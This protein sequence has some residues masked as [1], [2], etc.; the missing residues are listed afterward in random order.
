M[1]ETSG[2]QRVSVTGLTPVELAQA[3]SA[4]AALV[5]YTGDSL[6]AADVPAV[7]GELR[8]G[9]DALHF[10][11][12]FPF[13]AGLRYTARFQLP[14]RPPLLR[15]FEVAEPAGPPPRVTGVFPSGDVLP[16]NT[17]RLYVHFSQPMEAQGA[18]RHV[19]LLD[20]AGEPLTLPFV[21][22]E[23]GLWDPQQTRLTLLFHPGRIKRGVGPGESLGPPLRAGAEY[24]LVVDPGLRNARGQPLQAPFERRFRVGA[25]DRTSPR[26]AELRVA[27]PERADAPLEVS[28]P[29]PLDEAL[30]RRLVWIEDARGARLEGDIAVEAGETSWRFHPAR[31]W[32]PG[33][34]ALCVHPALEDRS[35]NRFDRP[36]DRDVTASQAEGES[37]AQRLPFRVRF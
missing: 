36:F 7:L 13:V 11:P 25:A 3:R 34:Y 32:A 35:G 16:E 37:A 20:A 31:P 2:R 24:R 23:H 15:T 26:I 12:R 5:V 21:E 4:A 17:L 28:L 6:P 30:L 9:P 8:P 1:V 27:A 10:E 33:D 19:R 29:E 18:A 14:G 22:I